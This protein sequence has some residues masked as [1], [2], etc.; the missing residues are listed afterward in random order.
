MPLV[1]LASS[2][3][4]DDTARLIASLPLYQQYGFTFE[5]AK[6]ALEKASHELKSEVLIAREG[7]EITGVAWFVKDGGFARSGYLRL[8]AVALKHQCS[9]VGRKLIE[10]LESR[11]LEPNGIFILATSTNEHAREFYEKLGYRKIGEV[12]DLVKNGLTEVIYYR[13]PRAPK[14]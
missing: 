6:E 12:P 5:K 3:D 13:P 11:Y 9:G 2:E 14:P 4:L 10:D 7:K 8:I 1:S